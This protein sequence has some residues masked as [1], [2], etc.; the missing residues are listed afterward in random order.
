[1]ETGKRGSVSVGPTRTLELLQ[2]HMTEA[3]CGPAFK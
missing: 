1:M 3:P 2:A